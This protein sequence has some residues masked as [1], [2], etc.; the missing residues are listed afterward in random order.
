MSKRKQILIA[1]PVLLIIVAAYGVTSSEEYQGIQEMK[2]PRYETGKHVGA[3]VCAGCHKEIYEAWSKNSVHAEATTNE[4]FIGFKDKFT[5]KL[6]LNVMMGEEMCYACH[7][8][9]EVNEGV[10]C[11]TCHGPMD[12]KLGINETHSQKYTP[13]LE[14]MRKADFCSKCHEFAPFMTPY[15]DWQKSEAA[16][17]GV[18]CQ[19]CHMKPREGDL[20]YHGFDSMSRSHSAEM[21]RGDLKITDIK[22]DNRELT[23]DIENQIKAHSLPA[24]GP[25]RLLVLEISFLD[26][27]GNEIHRIV[28]AFAKYFD[29]MPGVGLMPDKLIENTQLQS[30][31]KR[32]LSYTLPES[33]ESQISKAVLTLR[34]YDVSDEH[35]GDLEMAHWISEPFLEEEVNF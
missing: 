24:G 23:L 16:A 5:D 18:T 32:P 19:G 9:K 8:S 11:E 34:F 27:E 35:Q 15:S 31:E 28:E 10:N 30:S 12:L 2:K 3:Q 33:I 6:M 13:R 4:R 22:L 21:Y 29:L 20:P 17:E 1:L 14:E 26:K 7:G 25:N